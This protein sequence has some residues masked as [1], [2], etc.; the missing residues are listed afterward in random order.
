MKAISNAR[1]STREEDGYHHCEAD[2]VSIGT[3]YRWDR[4]AEC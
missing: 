4:A 2:N 1:S 3:A